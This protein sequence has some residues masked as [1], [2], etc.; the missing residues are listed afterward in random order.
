MHKHILIA[1]ITIFMASAANAQ[2]EFTCKL[3]ARTS[4][5]AF[6]KTKPQILRM[7]V[8]HPAAKTIWHAA[9]KIVCSK[10]VKPVV[11]SGVTHGCRWTVRV[12]GPKVQIAIE[13]IN[14]NARNAALVY[15][16]LNSYEGMHWLMRRL[17]Q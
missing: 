12:V 7:V 9:H 16:S 15:K 11:K 14:N 5:D 4:V 17:Q 6:C 13:E 8:P 10:P 1:L 3:L 2:E